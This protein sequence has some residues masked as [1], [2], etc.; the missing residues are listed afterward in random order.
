M[1]AVQPEQQEPLL[2]TEA[3][4]LE[5]EATSEIKHEFVAGK[6]FAMTGASWRHVIITQSTSAAL[7]N[8]LVDKPCFTAANDL[9][10]KVESKKVSFRYPDIMVI[11]DEPDFVEKRTDTIKNPTAIVQVLSPATALTDHNEKLDEY[12]KIDSVQAYVLISQHEAKVQVYARQTADEWRYTQ[13]NGLDGVVEL[14]SIGCTLALSKLYEK[15]NFE[16]D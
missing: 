12:I 13:T 10:V 11:C 15:V 14:T 7:Y 3:E 5:F 8:Q 6:V 4:Y 16:E 9:R 1:V 2:M